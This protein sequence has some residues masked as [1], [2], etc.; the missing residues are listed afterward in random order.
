MKITNASAHDTRR[1]EEVIDPANTRCDIYA[2]KGYIY[3]RHKIHLKEQGLRM[4]IQRKGGK[5]SRSRK[6]RDAGINASPKPGRV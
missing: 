3:G 4:H 5:T 6:R 1:F 2:D